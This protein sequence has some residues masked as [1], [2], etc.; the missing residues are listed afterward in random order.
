MFIFSEDFVLLLTLYKQLAAAGSK[1]VIRISHIVAFY[2]RAENSGGA[3]VIFT[4][5][6]GVLS[7]SYS[8]IFSFKIMNIYFYFRRILP[9]GI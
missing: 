1:I 8:R 6:T 2:I 3:D 5:G 9:E 7:I 4:L